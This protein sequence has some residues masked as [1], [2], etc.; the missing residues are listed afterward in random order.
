GLA[1]GTVVTEREKAQSMAYETSVL[2]RDLELARRLQTEAFPKVITLLGFRIAGTMLPAS[3]VGGDFYDVLYGTGFDFHFWLLVGDG[4]GPGLEAGLIVLMA[5]AA[6][7]ATLR[8]QLSMGP[9][10]L[11][12][13]VN[14][15]LY[16]N[17]RRRMSRDDFMTFMAIR[18]DGDGLF[19]LA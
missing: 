17:I 15:V 8:S 14:E 18:H 16:E 3:Q 6:A 19:H 1:L 4:S 11:V 5:Q 12:A 2:R 9:T 7:Q 10:K 13:R